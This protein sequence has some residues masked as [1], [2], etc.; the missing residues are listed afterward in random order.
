MIIRKLV[1]FFLALSTLLAAAVKPAAAQNP[2]GGNRPQYIIAMIALDWQGARADFEIKALSH[3]QLFIEESN[4][5]QYA[6][7]QIKLVKKGLDGVPLDTGWAEMLETILKFG[8]ENEPADR[9]VGLTDG[10]LAP[11]GN[12]GI[13]GWTSFNSNVLVSETTAGNEV[14]A[15]EL[16]HTYGLC[17]EYLFDVWSSQNTWTGGCPNPWPANCMP[18]GSLCEGAPAPNGSASIMSYAGRYGP[19]GYNRPCYDHLQDVFESMFQSGGFFETPTPQPPDETPTPGPTPTA[20]PSPSPSP[21]PT[22]APPFIYANPNLTRMNPPNALT[23]LFNEPAM[24]A[25]WSQDGLWVVFASSKDGNLNLYLTSAELPASSPQAL[26]SSS[27]REY[28]PRFMPD[29]QHIIYVS[30]ADGEEALYVLD[31]Q[32]HASEKMEGLPSPASWPSISADGHRLAFAAAPAGS[33][34][35]YI[36][37]LNSAGQPIPGSLEALVSSTAADISPDWSH[38]GALLAFASDRSGTL[39][40]Y[41]YQLDGKSTT[42][43]TSDPGNEWSPRWKKD[44]RLMYQRSL[45]SGLSIWEIN[46]V[47]LSTTRLLPGYGPA[48][49]PVPQP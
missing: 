12:N 22:P 7:V 1:V 39:D 40:L 19:F 20:T 29:G 36:V 27:R 37:D 38:D 17:D 13:A 5:E 24:Q 47:D 21:S 45:D 25:D 43:L 32:S 15:H 14:S 11:E 10:D 34:D 41:L 2:S 31:A 4:I 28:L 33:W 3:D 23:L 9:Y 48:G 46:P 18:D 49:W 44:G 26:T 35:I 8:L 16:G 30:D 6:D 42:A